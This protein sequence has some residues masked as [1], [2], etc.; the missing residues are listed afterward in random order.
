VAVDQRRSRLLATTVH[1][2]LASG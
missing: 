1:A 2:P